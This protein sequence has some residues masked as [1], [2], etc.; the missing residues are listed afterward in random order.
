M[1]C[2]KRLITVLLIL[3]SLDSFSK[4]VLPTVFSNN[5]VLQRQ[6]VVR[7]WGKAIPNS[8]I[9][10]TLPWSEKIIHTHSDSDGSWFVNVNTP[11]AG[12]PY[13]I[14]LDD[15]E[16]TK[17]DNIL[18]GDVWL[19]SGQSN[20][21]MPVRGYAKQP[22][23][24]SE[25][26]ISA[27]SSTTPI[28]FFTVKKGYSKNQKDDV[29]GIWREH[30]SKWV[31]DFSATAYFFGLQLYKTLGIPIGLI[32][33]SYGASRIESWM[34]EDILKL[35]PG[36]S[37]KHLYSEEDVEAKP[38]KYPVLLYNAM[39]YPLKDLCIKGVIWYQGEANRANP[40]Q[41]ERLLCDFVNQLRCLF[42]NPE[43]P[44][45]FAQIAPFSY[46]NK[47]KIEA[48]ELREAQY[49]CE[50]KISNSGMAVLMDLGEEKCIHPSR[51]KEV[52]ERLAY[53]AL[54]RSY[55]INGIPNYYPKYKDKKIVGNK[56]TLTFEHAEGGLTSLGR[57]LTN[58]TIAG[59]DS[60]FHQ[61]TAEIIGNKVKVWSENVNKPI[62]VRYG[63]FNYVKGDLF[64]TDG[65][66]VSSF[67]TDF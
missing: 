53:L 51:K 48:A 29:E 55:K 7:L 35:Y 19:C 27:A 58:F 56:I 26:T 50:R 8:N 32:N 5:M 17:L 24:G 33:T 23:I 36:I 65:L 40:K 15:G 44:F 38:Q 49:N 31:K 13:T 39:L 28:R 66:P 37:L 42:R 14:L 6:A 22:V 3:V 62:A 1:L 59:H 46:G 21:E 60:I 16:I 12:G 43:M 52:G 47:N 45:Y 9:N 2:V 20:M 67:R 64:G 4:V 41:Y 34:S 30:T 10:I 11:V 57:P 18:I 54:S 61:A 25:E 63:F